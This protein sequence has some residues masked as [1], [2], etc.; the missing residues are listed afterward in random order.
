MPLLS[1]RRRRWM[2]RA[3]ADVRPLYLAFSIRTWSSVP[4]AMPQALRVST[5][6]NRLTNSAIVATCGTHVWAMQGAGTLAAVL[7]AGQSFAIN[8][9]GCSE[10]TTAYA[11]GSARCISAK[12]ADI[13]RLS[14]LVWACPDQ[15]HSHYH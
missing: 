7:A 15:G 1:A 8:S 13:P 3:R 4:F 6:G 9:K 12:T 2:R 14:M 5:L 10:L 11:S